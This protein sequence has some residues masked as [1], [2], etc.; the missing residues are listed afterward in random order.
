VV[1]LYGVIVVLGVAPE[2]AGAVGL[3]GLQAA[4]LALVCIVLLA[5]GLAWE[6]LTTTPR[7]TEHPLPSPAPDRPGRPDGSSPGASD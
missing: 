5:H 4:A 1:V 2:A 6:F 7:A 3:S